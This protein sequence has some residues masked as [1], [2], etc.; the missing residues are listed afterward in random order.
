MWK[1]KQD[2]KPLSSQKESE[3][4]GQKQKIQV[5][6]PSRALQSQHLT[7]LPKPPE[8]KKYRTVESQVKN[9]ILID[10]KKGILL[11]IDLDSEPKPLTSQRLLK[12]INKIGYQEYNKLLVKV[13]AKHV[14][15]LFKKSNNRSSCRKGKSRARNYYIGEKKSKD[16]SILQLNLKKV[17][18]T[19]EIKLITNYRRRNHHTRDL[20]R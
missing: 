19:C 1:K 8:K 10:I 2:L 14:N 4:G 3:M 20:F 17:E 6:K 16:G 9:K 12:H 11:R 13:L 18:S 5:K 15:Y 7:D